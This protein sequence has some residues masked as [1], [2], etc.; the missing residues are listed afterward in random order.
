[1]NLLDHPV[2]DL[3]PS[4]TRKKLLSPVSEDKLTWDCFYTLYNNGLLS[5]TISKVVGI[6]HAPTTASTLV[7]W[8][9][10]IDEAPSNGRTIAV[11]QSQ[12]TASAFDPLQC[13]LDE[14]ENYRD[15]KP[16]GQKTEPDVLV[17]TTHF[18]FVFECKRGHGLGRCSRFEDCRC[19]EVH[20][21]R[22]KR[23]YC[24][25]W[26]R[27]LSS[28]VTFPRPKSAAE[29]PACNDFYQLIRNHMIGSKLAERLELSFCP[30]VVKSRKSPHYN[31]TEAEVAAFNATIGSA[32]HYRI[33]DWSS[34]REESCRLGVP[35]LE[36]YERELNSKPP[37]WS[38][39]PRRHG[40][41]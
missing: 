24:Q 16:E 40:G 25:Y 14:L 34:F 11:L 7:M 36:T 15:G 22:R 8:G 32:Q 29:V 1:M 26:E 13:V 39:N 5:R 31:E 21:D 27:G 35:I 23:S 9:W 37:D 30:V 19:P 20:V 2:Y 18:V 4:R 10:K 6:E 17:I 3:L 12:K 33:A 38:L 41:L 28:L